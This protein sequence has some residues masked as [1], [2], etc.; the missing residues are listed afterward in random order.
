M[1]AR[2]V[3][4]VGGDDALGLGDELGHERFLV[5]AV[6]LEPVDHHLAVVGIAHHDA[7]ALRRGTQHGRAADVGLLDHRLARGGRLGDL[8]GERVQVDAHQVDER[9]AEAFELGEIL[10]AVVRQEP[11]VNLPRQ[12]DD[13]MPEDRGAD[14][15]G[16]VAHAHARRLEMLRRPARSEKREPEFTEL[17]GELDDAVFVEHGKERDGGTGHENLRGGM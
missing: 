7:P 10:G 11:G 14:H 6:G 13:A 1:V 8:L 16:D 9:D 12:G 5:G 17:S 3:E 4:A 2:R 15:R